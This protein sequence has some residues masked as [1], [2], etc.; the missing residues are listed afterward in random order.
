MKRG[1]H[2]SDMKISIVMGISCVYS[3][4]EYIYVNVFVYLHIYISIPII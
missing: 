4:H 2:V 1:I 3:T